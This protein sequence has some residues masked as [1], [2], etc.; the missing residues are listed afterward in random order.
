[1]YQEN[2]Q[3]VFVILAISVTRP[4]RYCKYDK[5]LKSHQLTEPQ[6]FKQIKTC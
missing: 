2:D 1:M 4:V 5:T 3:F 6:L